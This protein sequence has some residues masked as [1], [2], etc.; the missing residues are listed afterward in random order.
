MIKYEK[1]PEPKKD[2]SGQP[3][4]LTDETMKQRREKVLK[5]M[6]EHNY[7]VLCIYGDV[8]HGFNLEYLVG[9]YTRFEEAML[10][11]H[12]NGEAYLLLGNENISR[13]KLARIENTSI[14]CSYFSLPQFS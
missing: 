6:A 12:K 8:D 13:G 1:R 7:D 2:F 14:H 4:W 11:L 9:F 5:Q 10:V 3:V